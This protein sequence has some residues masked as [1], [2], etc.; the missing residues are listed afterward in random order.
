MDNHLEKIILH[1]NY[2]VELR[3]RIKND[4]MANL[5]NF[6]SLVANLTTITEQNEIFKIIALEGCLPIKYQNTIYNIPIFCMLPSRYPFAAPVLYVKNPL[7]TW[8]QPSPILRE[9]GLVKH[10]TLMN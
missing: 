2:K 10:P 8:I 4:L 7:N 1:S 6:P 5:R 9:D 3:P